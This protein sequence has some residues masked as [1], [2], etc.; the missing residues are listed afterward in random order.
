MKQKL[1]FIAGVFTLVISA[2]LEARAQWVQTALRNGISGNC[3]AVNENDLFVGTDSGIFRSSDNGMDWLEVDSGFIG[4]NFVD[5]FQTSDGTLFAG[6]WGDGIYFSTNDGENWAKDSNGFPIYSEVT[7]FTSIGGSFFAG[8]TDSGVF[9]ST[10]NGK[11]WTYSGL[12][13][14][15]IT[16]LVEFG[17][18]LFAGTY[19]RIYL[20][21]DSGASWHSAD[22]GIVFGMIDGVSSFSAVGSNIF[23]GTNF[24]NIGSSG[25]GEVFLST[26]S[27]ASWN[28]V[29]SGLMCDNIFELV[30]DGPNLFAGTCGG[31]FLTT[32]NGSSWAE[33]DTGFI[34]DNEFSGIFALTVSAGYLFA[35]VDNGIWRRPLSDFNQSGVAE[36]T[37]LN[38]TLRIFPN[39]SSSSIQI[40]GGQP[41]EVHLFDLLGREVLTSSALPN[42]EGSLDVSHLSDGMYFLR[43]G[44]QSATVEILH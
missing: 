39:P 21:T 7:S 31:V 17:S 2:D 35:G 37:T 32:N 44:K 29:D 24:G 4:V 33:V 14:I 30:A 20:S 40:M 19:G 6:T 10:D 43:L 15:N 25:N 3:F 8:T 41:G 26:D 34:F 11:N 36:S 12:D 38:S 13:T 27:G 18:N 28:A 5:N 42:G 9:R 16:S 23:A 22:S 1:L